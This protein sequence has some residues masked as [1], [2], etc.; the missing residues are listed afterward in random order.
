VPPSGFP[1]VP[2]GNT[3]RAAIDCIKWWGIT[4]GRGSGVYDP[5]AGVTRAEMATFIARLVENSQGTLP[6]NPPDAFTDDEATGGHEASINKLAA[7]GVV[8]GK[9]GGIFD[10]GG[11]VNRE[12][13][14]TFL[15]RA[16]EYR[17]GKAL[18]AGTNVFPDVNAASTHGP[19]VNKAARA[20]FTGGRADGTYGPGL[21]VQRDQMASF[22]ARVLDLL[23]EADGARTP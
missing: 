13:M 20:G 18:T 12:Q 4:Q 19:N 2:S 21:G 10:P 17:S 16:Y 22:L 14:A 9:G 23:V 11:R 5:G 6:A 7:V 3:H 8:S 15:V 1:D